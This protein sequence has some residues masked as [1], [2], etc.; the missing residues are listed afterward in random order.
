MTKTFLSLEWK[1][2]TR[3]AAF[4]KGLVIKIFMFLGALYFGGIFIFLGVFLF[5]I[6][7]K[8]IPGVDP[9]I[10]INQYLL[11]WVLI[12]LA[13]RFFMHQL[14][15][16]NIKP[17]LVTPIKRPKIIRYLLNK[18][19][20]S[21]FNLGTLLF[22]VPFTAVLL[23]KGYPPIPVLAWFISLLCIILCLNFINFL[24]NKNNAYFYSIVSI[25]VVGITLNY[26]DV[27]SFTSISQRIFYPLYQQPYLVLLPIALMFLLYK[28]NY[29]LVSK[30]FFLD[31]IIRKK[32]EKVETKDLSFMDKFGDIAPFLKND[33]RMI[34]RNK[35]PKQVLLTGFFFVFYG[36]FFFTFDIYKDNLFMTSF[37]SIFIT[38]G[39]LLT[40]GQYVPSWDS[41]YYKLMMSQN[42]PYYQY[43]KSKWTLMVVGV[44]ASYIL[45]IPYLY[46]GVQIFAMIS[47][48]ALFNVGLNSFITLYGGA[49]NRV[50]IELNVKANAFG[51]T[52]GFNATQLL[53]S[54]PK[55]LGPYVIFI[56]PYYFLGFTAGVV[57]LAASGL[58]GLLLS[59]NFLRFIEKTYQ[60]GKYKT[61]AAFAEKQ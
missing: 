48:A 58:I 53:I 43:L 41:E 4:T 42:I 35:R 13:V 5:K 16:M 8:A 38:G 10:S 2:F 52:Q 3:S 11:Y 56:V 61:I 12:E 26:Y 7:E 37:A 28:A 21:F 33:V 57:A 19:I 14:P 9:M 18:T 51:N 39:F 24:I 31:G 54:L 23:Y 17:L 45:A 6:L 20:F 46:F 49:L 60:R 27:I 40:F 25:A 34:W 1:Q 55:M 50:P 15:V 59:K 22:L 36:L 30:Q 44:I 32:V 47:A 29:N